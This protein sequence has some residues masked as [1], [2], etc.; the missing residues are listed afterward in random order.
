MITKKDI[1]KFLEPKKLAIAGVS[2]NPKKF[3]HQVYEELKKKGFEVYPVNPQT[4]EI[5][6]RKMLSAVFLNYLPAWTVC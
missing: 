6:R 5:G 3:G 2:R 1:E 4:S